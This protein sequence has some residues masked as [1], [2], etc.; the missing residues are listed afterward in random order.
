MC[1]VKEL[2]EYLEQFPDDAT[3]EVL[4]EQYNR[5]NCSECIESPI[6]FNECFYV[7]NLNILVL[8]S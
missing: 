2:K 5:F 7:E 1:T 3:V 6:N 4:R 8:E